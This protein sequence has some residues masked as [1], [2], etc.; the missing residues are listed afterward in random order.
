MVRVI[1]VMSMVAIVAAIT[2][3]SAQPQSAPLAFEVGTIKATASTNGGVTGGCRGID[4]HY[5][6][7]DS[8]ATV[9]LGRCVISAGRLSHMM[10][11]AFNIS[12]QNIKG[13]P[14]WDGPSRFDLEAKAENPSRVTEQQLLLMLQQFLTDQFKLTIRHDTKQ[15]DIFLLALGKGGPKNMVPSEDGESVLPTPSGIAFTGSTMGRL[16]EI[17]TTMPT[18]GRPV[19]D[20]TGLQGR[21]DFNLSF[22]DKADSIANFK[23]ALSKWDSVFTDIQQLGL[24]LEA[25]KGP[26]ET[27]VIEHAEKPNN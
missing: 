15:A 5:G 10:G 1:A 24:R 23:E 27:L 2:S 7:N 17:L 4:S 25:S 14:D 20:I 11:I 6:A 18:V 21:F 3:I 16:A 12:L 22:G 13:F 26:I 19:K 9:P 8:R